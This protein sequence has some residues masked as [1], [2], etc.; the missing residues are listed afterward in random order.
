M[1]RCNTFLNTF[2]P[3]LLLLF[4]LGSC[5]DNTYTPKPRGYFRIT[6][7]DKKY[8]L[9]DSIYPYQ[10]EIPVYT[11]VTPDRLAPEEKDWINLEFT[12]LKGR[13]HLSYKKV[14]NRESLNR[15][16][17]DS[18]TLAF[19]HIP[20]ASSIEQVAIADPGKKIYGLCYNIKG[21]GAASPY[22]FYVTD[23]TRHFMRG[24]LYFDAV[25]NSDSLLPVIDFVKKDID[26]LLNTLEWK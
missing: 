4:F 13:L 8:R 2:I 14:E 9:L 6:L 21:L 17:E 16:L 19:K 26:H 10:F 24:A 12:G 7:P 22:Q 20:K 1:C 25:P 23:S 15:Y 5:T 18:R 3:V 11:L